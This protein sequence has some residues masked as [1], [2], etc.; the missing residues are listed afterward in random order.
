MIY[1]QAIQKATWLQLLLKK[2]GYSQLGSIILLCNYNSV[3]LLANN[4]KFNTR[5]KYINI[6]IYLI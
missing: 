3:I 1:Y 2:L 5:T 6:Q 4:L